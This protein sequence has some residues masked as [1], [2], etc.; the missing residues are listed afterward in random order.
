LSDKTLVVVEAG[1]YKTVKLLL[2]SALLLLASGWFLYHLGSQL[3]LETV[4]EDQ[5]LW[6]QAP[7]DK[8]LYLGGLM[9]LISGSL[10]AAAVQI[11]SA[12]KRGV[13]APT[14]TEP[15]AR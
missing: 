1:M 15:R 13:I 10:A 14:L 12:S 9:M 11:W 2:V 8:W 5:A 6:Q 3:N 4:K 7:G